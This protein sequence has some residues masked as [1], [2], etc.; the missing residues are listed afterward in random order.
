MQDVVRKTRLPNY[1]VIDQKTTLVI[2]KLVSMQYQSN[3]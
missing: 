2:R 3:Q 1:C